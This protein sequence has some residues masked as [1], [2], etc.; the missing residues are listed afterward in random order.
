VDGDMHESEA[1]NLLTDVVIAND[2]TIDDL[3]DSIDILM[4]SL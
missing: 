4:E 3:Y 2:G 1:R